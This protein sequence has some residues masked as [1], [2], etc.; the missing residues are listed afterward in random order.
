MARDDVTAADA[1]TA[2]D[3]HQAPA[4]P[5]AAATAP[6][7]PGDGDLPPTRSAT[8]RSARALLRTC[9]GTARA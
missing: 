2:Q 6:T 1:G 7:R 3:S 9:S 5:V 8:V 4:P